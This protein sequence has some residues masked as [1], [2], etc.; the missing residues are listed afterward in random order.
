MLL[1]EINTLEQRQKLNEL[2]ENKKKQFED[3]G[4]IN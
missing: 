1:K 3:N 2:Q 4:K